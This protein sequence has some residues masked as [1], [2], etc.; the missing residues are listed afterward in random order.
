VARRDFLAALSAANAGKGTTEADW[1][2]RRIGDGD[3][4]G[5]Q[6]VVARKELCFWVA[7][8]DLH[9]PSGRIAQGEGCR[10]RVP[11]E[12]QFLVPGYYYALGD[13]A[14]DGPIPGERD[15]G[16]LLRYYWHLTS[17]SAEAFVSVVTSLLNAAAVP[18]GLKVL[19]DPS[20]YT[21]ADAG[22]LYVGR[23]YAPKLGDA[24]AQIYESVA[25]GLRPEVPLFTQRLADGLALAEDP[26]HALSFGQ[27]RCKLVA[28]ALWRSF[29][30]GDASQDAR[31]ATLVATFREEG[32]DPQHP[33]LGP[34]SNLGNLQAAMPTLR[35][36]TI[37]RP[38][39]NG[40]PHL[41]PLD[42]AIRIAQALC[43]SAHWDRERRLCNWMGRSTS[44]VTQGGALAPTSSALGP[45]LYGGSAG[46]AL[47]LS[48]LYALTGDTS[49]R[50]TA[51]GA[52]ARSIRQVD[53][54][55]GDLASP[56]SF[57]CG[58]LGLAYA[59]HR[60]GDLMGDAELDGHAQALLDRLPDAIAA[61]HLL[62]LIGG[63]AGAIPALLALGP[64]S[65]RCTDWAVALG[66]ELCEAAE[67][68][69][70]TWT[71]DPNVASGPDTGSA[72]LTGLSHGAAGIGLALLE[73]YAVTGRSEFREGAR[74]AFT[75]EDSLFDPAQGNWPDLRGPTQPGAPPRYA[76]AWCHGAPGIALARLRA[77]ALDPADA[78][79]HLS[80]ARAAIA[81]TLQAIDQDLAPPSRDASLCHGLTGLMEILVIAGRSLGEP[82]WLAR[83]ATV[84]NTLIDR[85]AIPG[86]WPSG[87][88][89][90]GPNP[91][92]ML[93][94][95]GIGYTFL[96]LHDPDS[97]PS[98]LL[99]AL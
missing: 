76:R 91:S 46:V 35:L 56:V 85:H 24:I 9:V 62:D 16:P 80:V 40:K 1:T 96:R 2:V 28:C 19:S 55:P 49:C 21:R 81:T 79:T 12:L 8:S 33:E 11:K 15:G 27:H 32:L 86:D 41:T 26:G 70:G 75:Y 39:P 52:I 93:G 13:A 30:Q 87:V 71:W 50:T 25:F 78:E 95:A 57:F 45:D 37:P 92:L 53:R 61:P 48:Q 20:A 29:L 6:V 84:A 66:E 17:E 51:L 36:R 4:D 54:R 42:A 74:G 73:L 23:Q 64:M 58:Y 34:Q 99:L 69:D 77:A 43:R 38:S 7:A 90:G 47:F 44:E 89:T 3:G 88:A 31:A 10:V 22:V 65:A 63:N 59:A 67:R 97:V 60:I 72:P 5:A 18:F 94:L 82:S 98:V 83:A 14:D 68:K